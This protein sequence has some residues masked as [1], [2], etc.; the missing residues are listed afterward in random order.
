MNKQEK[1]DLV[2]SLGATL[3]SASSVVLVNFAGLSVKLQQSLKKELK[4][5]DA[6]MV[7]VKNTLIK[8]AAKDANLD[9][10]TVT[11]EVLTGQTALVVSKNDPVAAIQVLGK[12]I[13]ENQVPTFKVGVVEGSFQDQVSLEKISTLPG[14]DTLLSQVLGGLMSPMYGLVGTLNGN[15]QKLVYLLDQKSKQKVGD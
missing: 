5:V 14:K 3:Q 7:V 11:D 2:K 6:D 12:F 8:L 10:K 15:M 4:S 9:E 1:I 13:K